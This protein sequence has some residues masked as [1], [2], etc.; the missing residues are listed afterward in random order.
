[1][2]RSYIPSQSSGLPLLPPLCSASPVSGLPLSSASHLCTSDPPPATWGRHLPPETLSPTFAPLHGLWSSPCP[3]VTVPTCPLSRFTRVHL[4]TVS[5]SPRPTGQPINWSTSLSRS[6]AP[7]GLPVYLLPNCGCP[8][9]RLS[10]S[11]RSA[12]LN[13]SGNFFV[14]R[15]Q[16]SN[17]SFSMSG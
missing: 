9:I 5:L 2:L 17:Q 7:P 12:S 15:L 11:A 10:I 4:C 8:M 14:E 6:R 1:M 13:P 16:R 3:H